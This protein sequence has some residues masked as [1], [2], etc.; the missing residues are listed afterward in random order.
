MSCTR[1]LPLIALAVALVAPVL[2][3]EKKDEKTNAPPRITM[4][5]PFAVVP[6]VTNKIIVRGTS[7][8]NATEI[9]FPSPGQKPVVKI[10]SRGKATVPEKG[11]PKK[12]GDTQLEVR[13]W[14]PSDFAAGDLPFAVSTAEG[15][16]NTNLLHVVAQ[17]SL[18]DEKEPNPG[19]R[20]ANPIGVPQMVR[21]VI[22]EASDVD[23]F[24]FQ[25]R[26]GQRV[27]I[28]TKSTR[29]G[30]SLDPIL[31]LYDAKGH[32]LATSD[33]T[34]GLDAR[35]TAVL[36]RDEGYF[37]SINDAHD[38]GGPTYGYVVEIRAE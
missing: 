5:L 36:P 32:V 30:S 3:A 38:R 10:T 33:D 20:K 13:L 11:D 21:G 19:I 18:L 22:G 28:E 4:S 37:I 15:D 24:R 17:A 12:L 31:N 2:G 1:K 7:L 8:T 27:S 16:T 29:Y 34:A 35:I 23:V 9:R 26:S 25:G 6:G 14:L